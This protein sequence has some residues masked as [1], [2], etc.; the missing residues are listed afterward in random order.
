MTLQREKPD[1]VLCCKEP[2]EQARGGKRTG[3]PARAS[4]EFGARCAGR[5]A[6][7]APFLLPKYSALGFSKE[8]FIPEFTLPTVH[9]SS[10]LCLLRRKH[11][12]GCSSEMNHGP[13]SELPATTLLLTQQF[14]AAAFA[15][16]SAKG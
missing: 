3:K 2:Q 6:D 4:S 5:K 13:I 7:G 8:K 9:P 1:N 14:K 12:T 11:F 10:L 16:C 15:D